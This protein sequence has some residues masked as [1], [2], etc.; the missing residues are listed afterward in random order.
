[1]GTDESIAM[2]RKQDATRGKR[3]LWTDQTWVVDA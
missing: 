3:P 2:V 1:M